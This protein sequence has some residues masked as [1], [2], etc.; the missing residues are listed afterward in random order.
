MVCSA[1]SD[2]DSNDAILYQNPS[3][4][5]VTQGATKIVLLDSGGTDIR[6]P[7]IQAVDS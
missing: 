3:L 7:D 1:R 2:E 5:I 4:S 6:D